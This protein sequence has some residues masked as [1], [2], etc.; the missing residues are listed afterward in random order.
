MKKMILIAI[1]FLIIAVVTFKYVYKDHR[2]IVSER[3]EFIVESEDLILEF[4]SNSEL[5]SQKYLNKT[6][7]VVGIIT[8]IEKD[9]V[10]LN[11]SIVCYVVNAGNN[12]PTLNSH[13]IVKGRFIG[14]DDLL[15]EIKIDQTSIIK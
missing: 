8:G 5:A 12:I 3:A 14:Y 15:E 7:E 2:D 10:M 4:D 13:V 1:V 11:N 6:I 9:I